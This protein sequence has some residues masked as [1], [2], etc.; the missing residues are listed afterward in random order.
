MADL[1]AAV[2]SE[3][4][5]T[6]PI[7][8]TPTKRV[9]VARFT[10][11]L[12]NKLI[13]NLNLS[14]NAGMRRV[15]QGALC[16]AL[17]VAM[18]PLQT[19]AAAVTTC[20][21]V[22]VV[23]HRGTD[24]GVARNNTVAAFQKAAADKAA[25]IELDVQRTKPDASGSGTWVVSHDSTLNGYTISKTPYATLKKS[26]PDLAT[27]RDAMKV[28]AATPA[29]MEV[30]IK[31]SSVGDGS[32]KYFVSLAKEYKMTSRLRI[33]S[34]S[35][36]VLKQFNA[37]KSGIATGYNVTTLPSTKPADIAAFA[38]KVRT[39]ATSINVNKTNLTSATV[40]TQLKSAPG[41]QVNTYTV[42][43]ST[44][45]NK[46]VG[47]GVNG[48]ITDKAGAYNTWCSGVVAASKPKV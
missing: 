39:F 33:T 12:Y 29:R 6:N 19:R 1:V 28:I 46:L 20:T 31:P 14:T 25:V 37:L 47:F 15:V 34:F 10:F 7:D 5:K 43:T 44:E 16:L 30:E 40:V 23:G 32:L 45:W 18:L 11:W 24:V 41:L 9:R 3:S 21:T 4:N 27:I 42:D 22:T 2:V 13:M 48:I 36:S 17:I 8:E 38:K 26:Q 35:E